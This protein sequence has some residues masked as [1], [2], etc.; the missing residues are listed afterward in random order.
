MKR[1]D[2]VLETLLGL[3]V[4]VMV[5]GCFWQ[6]FTRFVLNSPSK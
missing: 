2:K 1:L 6:V 3:M 4:A 5:L